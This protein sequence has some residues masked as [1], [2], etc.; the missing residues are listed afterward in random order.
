MGYRHPDVGKLAVWGSWHVRVRN[1]SKENDMPTIR[2]AAQGILADDNA[3]TREQIIEM[4]KKAYW[5]E[6][7]TVMSY[8]AN[9]I[10]PD[11]VRAQEIVESLQQD[12][13]E[14]LGHAQQFAQ[15][16]KELYGVVPGSLE[17]SAEQSYLQPP[18]EQTDIVHVIKGVI[19]AETGA[20]EHYNAI[21][22]ATDETDPVTNDMVIAILRDEE[23]HRRLFEGYLREYEAEGRA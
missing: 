9:S 20:I 4:L 15:R 1:Q 18:D 5:M 11:G 10:N 22:E 7:E 23:G 12:I 3:Q 8:I 21:I 6:I 16:I 17:F 13:T 19:E 2:S 14:E